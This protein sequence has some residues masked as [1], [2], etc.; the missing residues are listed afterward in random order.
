MN[1]WFIITLV[2]VVGVIGA[3]WFLFVFDDTASNSDAGPTEFDDS[4]TSDPDHK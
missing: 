4:D 3:A 1:I 2:L